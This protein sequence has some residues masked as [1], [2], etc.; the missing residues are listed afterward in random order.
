MSINRLLNQTCSIATYSATNKFGEES[1]GAGTSVKCRFQE[2]NKIIKGPDGEDIGTD[3][4]VFLPS[5]ATVGF[6]DRITFDSVNYQVVHVSKPVGR[7]SVNHYE[8]RLRRIT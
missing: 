3:A 8:V 1:Y 2:E 4:L 7:S 6:G 5:T